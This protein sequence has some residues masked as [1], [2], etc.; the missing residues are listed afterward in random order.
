MQRQ[1]DCSDN[2]NKNDDAKGISEDMQ[3]SEKLL[4][5][6]ELDEGIDSCGVESASSPFESTLSINE[7]EDEDFLI[8]LDN[9]FDIE[10]EF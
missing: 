4:F 8:G 1:N 5:Y 6:D 7:L 9:F 2:I 3:T 10:N